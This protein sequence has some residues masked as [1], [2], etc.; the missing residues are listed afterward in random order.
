MQNVEAIRT[1]ANQ[2]EDGTANMAYQSS[3]VTPL[4]LQNFSHNVH[5]THINHRAQA[6]T[7]QT[8]KHTKNKAPTKRK[9]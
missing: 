9:L 3:L 6:Y 1:N 2:F 7:K 5:S 4:A 8:N